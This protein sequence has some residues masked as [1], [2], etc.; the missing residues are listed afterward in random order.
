[1]IMKGVSSASFF[2]QV[3][4]MLEIFLKSSD[5]SIIVISLEKLLYATFLPIITCSFFRQI[6][7]RQ[8]TPRKM[9]KLKKTVV[10]NLPCRLRAFLYSKDPRRDVINQLEAWTRSCS[11]FKEETDLFGV[12]PESIRSNLTVI[13]IVLLM[14]VLRLSI[15]WILFFWIVQELILLQDPGPFPS[16]R[17]GYIPGPNFEHVYFMNKLLKIIWNKAL[18]P[19]A[20]ESLKPYLQELIPDRFNIRIDSLDLGPNAPFFTFV[21]SHVSGLNRL[22]NSHETTTLDFGLALRAR[23]EI[24]ASF[25]QDLASFGLREL[26]L[27]IPVRIKLWPMFRDDTVFGQLQLLVLD[28][29]KLDYRVQDPFGLLN[30]NPLK[31]I[32]IFAFSQ[33]VART[34]MF[35]RGLTLPMV[36]EKDY[37][38]HMLNPL[39]V[40]GILRIGIVEAR[41]LRTR[42]FFRCLCIGRPNAFCVIEMER[43]HLRTKL[44]IRDSNPRWKYLCE[45]ALIRSRD[46]CDLPQLQIVVMHK[47]LCKLGSPDSK[48]GMVSLSTERLAARGKFLDRWFRLQGQSDDA[49]IRIMTQYAEVGSS[50][51]LRLLPLPPHRSLSQA[52]LSVLVHRV[53]MSTAFAPVVSMRLTGRPLARTS[54]GSVAKTWEFAEQFYFP[55]HD[56]DTDRFQL[57]LERCD[58]T[59]GTVAWSQRFLKRVRDLAEEVENVKDS[60]YQQQAEED[61]LEDTK[62]TL[63]AE[64]VLSLRDGF[65]WRRE[66]IP[67]S[68]RGSASCSIILEARMHYVHQ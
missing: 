20:R 2:A 30:L 56:L 32:L 44:V 28:V 61:E 47:H 66:R 65:T 55:V 31:Q 4:T 48:L 10:R 25:A 59:L 53:E 41:G 68:S 19:F 16:I 11:R 46:G 24:V 54:V 21:T 45:Y 33:G 60:S 64:T 40:G 38:D 49:E 12:F 67:L 27:D 15:Y 52:I 18:R 8:K 6:V 13:S 17:T 43:R 22:E 1:M 26:D 9:E 35:P 23:T 39:S 62:L 14:S 37:P 57:S 3:I 34:L 29:P 63:M 36:E 51:D 50:A 7:N 42:D 58:C 5:L